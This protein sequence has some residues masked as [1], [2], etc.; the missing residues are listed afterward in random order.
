[1]T[2]GTPPNQ[3]PP[4]QG[5]QPG[6]SSPEG[7]QPSPYGQQPPYGQP[8]Y[9]QP[10]YGQ[11]PA[12]PG[13]GQ[14]GQTPYGQTTPRDPD[15]RPGTVLAACIITWVFA[16]LAGLLGVFMLI[17]V[18]A[19]RDE[20]IDG[21]EESEGYEDMVDAGVSATEIADWSSVSSGVFAAL[22]ILAMVVAWFAFRRSNG[23]RIALVVLSGLTAVLTGVGAAVACVPGVWTLAAIAVIVLLFTGGA[24]DWYAR[25]Q[26]G[27]TQ[28]PQYGQPG[29]YDQWPPQA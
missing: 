17:V 6:Q 11:P 15:R 21:V 20:F 12:Q 3:D 23:A 24:N 14:Y 9:G 7:E 28:P 4:S 25:R 19:A 10:A 5:D 8:A 29:G 16:G 27:Q 2:E 1:M 13:Y 22:A 18:A 26:P